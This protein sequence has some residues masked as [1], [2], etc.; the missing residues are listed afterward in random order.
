[1]LNET[2]TNG[3]EDIATKPTRFKAK[4]ATTDPYALLVRWRDVVFALTSDP[5]LHDRMSK[6]RHTE[7]LDLRRETN[8]LLAA[9]REG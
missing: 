3:T 1:M 8:E 7:I 4:P 6:M 9:R 2:Y 5:E